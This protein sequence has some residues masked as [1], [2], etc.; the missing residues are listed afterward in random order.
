LRKIILVV[1]LSMDGYAAGE[2]G[3]FDEFK[4]SPETWILFAG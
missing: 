2:K 4:P 1:H 3:E